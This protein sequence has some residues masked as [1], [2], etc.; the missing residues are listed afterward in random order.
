MID[1]RIPVAVDGKTKLIA[2]TAAQITEI[3][4]MYAAQNALLSAI[5]GKQCAVSRELELVVRQVYGKSV[6]AVT[7]NEKL[8]HNV[9]R[10]VHPGVRLQNDVWVETAEII[11]REHARSTYA[12]QNNTATMMV[13][14]NNTAATCKSIDA[15]RE[16]EQRIAPADAEL[17]VFSFQISSEQTIIGIAPKSFYDKLK[18]DT[19]WNDTV[20]NWLADML[21]GDSKDQFILPVCCGKV[22]IYKQR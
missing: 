16:L 13:T 11:L 19:A 7:E 18:N 6:S 9:T 4:T 14:E 1:Y 2:L 10:R 15:V 5:L 3:G 12:N 22:Y 8:I 17:T 20:E 21:A